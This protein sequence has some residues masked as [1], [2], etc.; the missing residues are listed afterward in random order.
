M[1]NNKWVLPTV[2]TV[3]S[4]CCIAG[5]VLAVP[6]AK[7][8]A[9]R[10]YPASANVQPSDNPSSDTSDSG[11]DSALDSLVA[12]SKGMMAFNWEEATWIGDGK[13]GTLIIATNA[14]NQ[15]LCVYEAPGNAGNFTSGKIQGN[16]VMAVAP[17]SEF[18]DAGNEADC[19]SRYYVGPNSTPSGW[20]S[21]VPAGWDFWIN[22]D[23]YEAHNDEAKWTDHGDNYGKALTLGGA[24]VATYFQGWDKGSIL[25]RIIVVGPKVTVSTSYGVEGTHWDVSGDEFTNVLTTINTMNGEQEANFKANGGT[26][27]K[28][29]NLYIGEGNAPAGWTKDLP[30]GWKVSKN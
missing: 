24:D 19:N 3:I 16:F 2:I 5:I 22:Q 18:I 17:E 6:F 14:L 20:D 11:N 12:K 13:M 1:K 27:S 10:I 28:I 21:E 23:I 7:N 30:S 8:L 29:I 4:L 15:T 26:P 25:V 9:N